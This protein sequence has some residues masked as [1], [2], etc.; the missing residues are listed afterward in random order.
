MSRIMTTMAEMESRMLSQRIKAGLREGRKRRLPLRGRAPW[1]YRL[2]AERTALEPHPV[3]WHRA[4][5]FLAL[6]RSTSWRM[7]T[8]LDRWAAEGRGDIPLHSCRAVRAWLMN[9]IL[10]GGLGYQQ[11]KNHRYAIEVWDTH[12]ALIS[13][14]EYEGLTAQLE[15]NRRMWGHNSTIIPRLLTSLCRCSHCGKAMSY[16]GGR[17][18]PAVLCKTRGCAQQYKSTRESAI[19]DAVLV[20]ISGRAL[21]LATLIAEEPPEAQVLR[22]AIQRLEALQDPDLTEAISAKRERLARVQQAD[23]VDPQLLELLSRPRTL[24]H[25]APERLRALFQQLV[26]CVMV[27]DQAVAEVQL[28]I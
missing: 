6:L 10:R 23:P 15:E 18:V 9:P 4:E 16:A 20:A 19:K 1:G 21:S 8:A 7:N 27:R 5:D 22:D 11:Q 14:T 25:L 12:L 3:E 26:V 28:R 17:S 13:H 2:N 24:S